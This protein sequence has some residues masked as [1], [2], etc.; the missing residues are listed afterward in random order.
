[1]KTKLNSVFS[2]ALVFTLM[3]CQQVSNEDVD[4]PTITVENPKEPASEP[5]SQKEQ[6][7]VKTMQ[8]VESADAKADARKS[9]KNNTGSKPELIAFAG[10]SLS[11][12]GLTSAQYE[13][14]KG[15]VTPRYAEGSGDVLHGD[16]HKAMR[17]KLHAYASEYNA[18][19]YSAVLK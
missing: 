15:K 1:M 19:I 3:G 10:R 7:I 11:F 13:E 12:P 14:I 9:L 5:M 6:E 2:I 4:T 18:V 17:K 8:W 16:T